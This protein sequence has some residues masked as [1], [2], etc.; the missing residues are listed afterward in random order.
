MIAVEHML[1]CSP[2]QDSHVN[3]A[4]A[5]IWLQFVVSEHVHPPPLC[6]RSVIIQVGRGVCRCMSLLWATCACCSAVSV[7]QCAPT[8]SMCSTWSFMAL[9]MIKYL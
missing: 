8:R 3:G 6:S 1:T 5:R 7:S 2:S 4:P 9:H